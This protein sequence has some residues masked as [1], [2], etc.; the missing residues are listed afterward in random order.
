MAA[1]VKRYIL[2]CDLCQRVKYLSISMEGEYQFIPSAGPNDL[3]TVDYYG[4]LPMARGGNQYIFVM[5][6]AFSK[7]VSLYT[8][9]SATARM[10]LKKIFNNFIPKFGKPKRIL[11]DHGTQFTA[12]LCKNQLESEGITVLYSSI[13]HPQSNPTERVMRELG[14]LFRTLCADKHAKWVE[15]VPHIKKV[16]NITVH[17]AYHRNNYISVCPFGKRSTN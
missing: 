9:K 2:Y 12:A 7:Y 13:R 6:D 16:L 1:Q 14:R 15:F 17:Q 5:L 8:M 4:P 3:V 10:T 11:S